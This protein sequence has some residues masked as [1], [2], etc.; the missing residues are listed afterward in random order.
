MLISTEAGRT[1]GLLNKWRKYSCGL[2][3]VPDIARE[4]TSVAPRPLK[5]GE[6]V[7]AKIERAD[8]YNLHGSV[9]RF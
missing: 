8:E 1:A 3:E 2:F 5:V 9:A 4:P 7:T 6:I